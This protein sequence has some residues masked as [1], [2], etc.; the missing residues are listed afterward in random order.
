V[1]P[2]TGVGMVLSP[3]GA[4]GGWTSRPLSVAWY[5]RSLNNAYTRQRSVDNA[6]VAVY[7]VAAT[8]SGVV[9]GYKGRFTLSYV[10]RNNPY[11]APQTFTISHSFTLGNEVR[12]TVPEPSIPALATV[13]LGLLD[14]GG[15][16]KLLRRR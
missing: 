6:S 8:P 7:Y 5:T 12:T 3:D 10:T 15:M 1:S 2:T 4:V 13:L 14:L 11:N 9:G 16:G